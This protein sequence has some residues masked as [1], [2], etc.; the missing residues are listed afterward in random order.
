MSQSCDLQPQSRSASDLSEPMEEEESPTELECRKKE[1]VSDKC[2]VVSLSGNSAHPRFLGSMLSVNQLQAVKDFMNP[3]LIVKHPSFY[4]SDPFQ[5]M[6]KEF[7]S[8]IAPSML[9]AA[10]VLCE[11]NHPLYADV[12]A[13]CAQRLPLRVIRNMKA[14]VA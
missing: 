6:K 10:E 3:E 8:V 2:Q 9:G 12:A 11:T 13:S 4:G 5:G 1:R 14:G 7:G